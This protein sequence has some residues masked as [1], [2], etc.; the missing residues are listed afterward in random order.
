M[1]FLK[2]LYALQ[3]RLGIQLDSGIEAKYEYAKNLYDE[4]A[5]ERAEL[6]RL[7]ISSDDLR[8]MIAKRKSEKQCTGPT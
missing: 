8:R 6:A 5:P 4:L 7:G 3:T 2:T 1:E